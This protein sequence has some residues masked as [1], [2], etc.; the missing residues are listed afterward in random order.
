MAANF[1]SFDMR[2]LLGSSLHTR[3]CAEDLRACHAEASVRPAL[4]PAMPVGGRRNNVAAPF[5][6]LW[7]EL[8]TEKGLLG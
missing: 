7:S 1:V 4:R 8:S 2:R 3:A 5:L 6:A